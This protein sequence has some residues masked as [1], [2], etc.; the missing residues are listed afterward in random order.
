MQLKTALLFFL[1]SAERVEELCALTI[2]D[3]CLCWRPDGT[4]V[5]LWP[6]P[7]FLPK[8]LNPQLSSG[9]RSI[10]SSFFVTGR[11]G[12]FANPMSSKGIAHICTF[13]SAFEEVSFSTFCLLWKGQTKVVSKQHVSRWLVDVISYAYT[14]RG[15]P[16]PLGIQAH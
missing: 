5:S 7:A 11:T 6:S 15:L 12:G 16:V 9:G 8:I 14:E 1:C 13:Y 10:S 4:G 2:S 3:D